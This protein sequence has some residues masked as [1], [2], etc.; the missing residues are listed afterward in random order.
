MPRFGQLL[1]SYLP[2]DFTNEADV[3]LYG[4]PTR[5]QDVNMTP[6]PDFDLGDTAA[7]ASADTVK[8]FT[9]GVDPMVNNLN[10]PAVTGCVCT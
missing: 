4:R 5:E 8:D 1:V 9:D 2:R 10:N 3:S 7:T 6:D